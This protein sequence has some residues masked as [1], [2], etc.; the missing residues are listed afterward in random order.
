MDRI[1]LHVEVSP[2]P[3]YQ[4]RERGNGESSESIRQRVIK[5][6]EI[7]MERYKEVPG[8]YTNAQMTSRQLKDYCNIN[9]EC[10]SLLFNAMQRLHLSVRAY[11]RILKMSRTIADLAGSENIE[12]QHLTESIQYRSLDRDAWSE[13]NYRKPKMY[14]D[15]KDFNPQH[16]RVANM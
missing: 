7:Q 3:F 1:D 4:L 2:L 16:L 9:K 8:L 5:A 13:N 11:D 6:R 10:E 12:I 15:K 14:T